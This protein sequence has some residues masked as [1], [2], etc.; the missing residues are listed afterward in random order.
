MLK[1]DLFDT[2]TMQNDSIAYAKHVLA[3]SY[4]SFTVLG[5]QGGGTTPQ[6]SGDQPA[7]VVLQPPQL[8]NGRPSPLFEVLI[9]LCG[10]LKRPMDLCGS[11]GARWDPVGACGNL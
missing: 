2:V 7:D 6:G 4:V 5:C 1:T 3:L 8:K 10:P 11:M 9:V